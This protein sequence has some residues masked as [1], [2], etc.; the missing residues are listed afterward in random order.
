MKQLITIDVRIQDEMVAPIIEDRG[1][2]ATSHGELH[3]DH[4][5]YTG[6]LIEFPSEEDCLAYALQY[7]TTISFAEYKEYL[8]RQHEANN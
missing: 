1:F 8:R 6:V 4:W 7:G 3:C 2:K 5:M